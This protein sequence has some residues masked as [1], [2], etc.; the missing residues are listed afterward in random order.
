M[1]AECLR[2]GLTSLRC[3]EKWADENEKDR[4]E[5]FI[6][7]TEASGIWE[8]DKKK[9]DDKGHFLAFY[10]NLAIYFLNACST[11]HY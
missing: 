3:L 6:D 10:F 7:V 5:R 9:D 1:R 8:E 2:G 11:N 4:L